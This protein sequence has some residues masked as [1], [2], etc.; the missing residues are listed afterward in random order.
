MMP[1]KGALIVIR[2]SSSCALRRAAS[3][4]FSAVSAS[5]IATLGYGA[6][7]EL[8]VAL[9]SIVGCARCAAA[10]STVTFS[11]AASSST[12]G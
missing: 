3:A 2:S 9:Y 6:F 4:T 10:V 5:A 8:L 7:V 11:V 1:L 12:R